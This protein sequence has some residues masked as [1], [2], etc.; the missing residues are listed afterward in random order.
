MPTTAA[1]A[2]DTMLEAQSRHAPSAAGSEP[3]GFLAEL[4]R[5]A[6]FREVVPSFNPR[7]IRLNV[8]ERWVRKR[9]RLKSK[10]Q[11]MYRGLHIECLKQSR[12]ARDA[13]SNRAVKRS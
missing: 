11:L 12:K 13:Q 1:Y 2:G 6:D 4:E 9:L 5:L 7:A 10:D 3:R 8:T